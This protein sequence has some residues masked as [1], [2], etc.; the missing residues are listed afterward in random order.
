MKCSCRP[1]GHL[2]PGR[3]QGFPHTSRLEGR[4]RQPVRRS[5]LHDTHRPPLTEWALISLI[6]LPLRLTCLTRQRR[7][8][9]HRQ[10]Q[11]DRCSSP[12][13]GPAFLGFADQEW[14]HLQVRLVEMNLVSPEPS[15][16]EITQ[17]KGWA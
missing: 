3:P 7:A 16:S 6:P 12:G 9:G 13:P 8:S 5:S 4:P 11:V 15:A 10:R 2:Q 14:K 1:C 17:P